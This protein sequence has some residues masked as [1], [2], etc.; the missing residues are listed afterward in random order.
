MDKTR[1]NGSFEGRGAR[2]D[3][4]P[5]DV[6][7]KAASAWDELANDML[8][9]ETIKTA[10]HLELYILER[11]AMIRLAYAQAYQ[12]AVTNRLLGHLV[13]AVNGL[14]VALGEEEAGG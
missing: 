11:R 7:L 13:H 2:G 5:L 14:A 9:Q 1:V 4:D 3:A 8:A 6:A 12:A 10:D